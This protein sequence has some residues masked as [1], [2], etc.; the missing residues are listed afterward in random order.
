MSYDPK[1]KTQVARWGKRS[2]K[3]IIDVPIMEEKQFGRNPFSDQKK[4]KK[5]RVLKNNLKQ[6]KNREYNAKNKK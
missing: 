6:T 2:K 3:N 5:L 4:E 1:L